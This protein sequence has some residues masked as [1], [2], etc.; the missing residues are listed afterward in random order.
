MKLKT[1]AAGAMLALSMALPAQAGLLFSG[2]GGNLAAS[3]NFT[4]TG[5]T[6]TVVLTNTS[7]FDVLVPA[8]VLTAVLFSIPNSVSLTATSALLSSGS[9]VF[10]DLQGQPA[11]GNVGGEWGYASGLSGTPQGATNGISSSGLG[12]LFGQPNF[13]GPDLQSPNALDGLQYGI[14]SASDNTGTGNGGITGSG[15]LIKNS[16]TFTLG[17]TGTLTYA[18]IGKVSFQ[19]GT[20]MNE[21]NLS[22]GCAK[23]DPNCNPDPST[24]VPEPAGLALVGLGLAAISLIRRRRQ[25]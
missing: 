9:T 10:Y 2:S 23:T 6:L 13:N 5:N 14:L 12:G 4:I 15:G 11:G 3:A 8:D 1:V 25:G 17:I 16:V 24:P 7:T 18:D 22:G 21:P 20:A 19:Y